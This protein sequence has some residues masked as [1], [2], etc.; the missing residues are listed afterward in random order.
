M[1]KLPQNLRSMHTDAYA[2]CERFHDMGN[3]P[4]EWETAAEMMN[5]VAAHHNHHPLMQR[6]LFAVYDWMDSERNGDTWKR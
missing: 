4:D 5:S 2:Y 1:S 6:L 3:T